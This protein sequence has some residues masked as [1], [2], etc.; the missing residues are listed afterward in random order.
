MLRIQLDRSRRS[1]RQPMLKPAPAAAQIVY[2]AD[3]C[4]PVPAAT[5]GR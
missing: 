2:L 3:D 4:R 1:A 5:A